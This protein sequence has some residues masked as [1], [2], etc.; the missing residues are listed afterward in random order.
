MQLP[1]NITEALEQ[2]GRAEIDAKTRKDMAGNPSTEA[3]DREVQY[4]QGEEV[5][6]IKALSEREQIVCW[7]F[8]MSAADYSKGK[9]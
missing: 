8:K 6:A 1:G 5:E 9:R 3:V 7:K 2:R 4:R